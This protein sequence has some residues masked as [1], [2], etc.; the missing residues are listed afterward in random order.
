VIAAIALLGLIILAAPVSAGQPSNPVVDPG[1]RTLLQ[2]GRARVLVELRV[3]RGEADL[4]PADA[5]KNVQEAVLS[6]LAGSQAS[7]ARRYTTVPLLALEIDAHALSVLETMSDAVV[8]VRADGTA[9]P[10]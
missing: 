5:I 10:Q 4:S 6:R 7:V 2:K 9:R 8:R 1:V 3:P